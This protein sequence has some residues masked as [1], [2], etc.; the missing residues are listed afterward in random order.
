M[1][2]NGWRRYYWDDLK[3]YFGRPLAGWNDTG[4][5]LEGE[6][7]SLWGGKPVSGGPVQLGPFSGQF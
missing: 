6:V 3:D 1:M 4:L 5:T 7:P 2:V